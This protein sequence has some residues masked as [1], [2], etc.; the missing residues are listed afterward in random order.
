MAS[1]TTR[2]KWAGSF[3][4][5][6]SILLVAPRTSISITK[7]ARQSATGFSRISASVSADRRFGHSLISGG[8]TRGSLDNHAS[9]KMKDDGAPIALPLFFE[10]NQGQS[11]SAVRFLARSSGYTMFVTP[12]ETVFAEVQHFKEPGMQAG[13]TESDATIHAQLRMSLLNGN[14]APNVTGEHPLAG[15]VNYLIGN[16]PSQWHTKVPLYSA[17]RSKNV[18]PGI[19]L[20]F[21]GDQQRLEYDFVVSPDADPGRIRF[22]VTGAEK[23][24]LAQNGDLVLR[25]AQTEFRMRK[26]VVYQLDGG[27]RLPVRG[28][29]SLMRNGQV[30]FQL[31]AYNRKLP[32]VIDP[33]I[34]FAT[35]IGSA[36]EELPGGIDLDTTNP[37]APKLY[38]AG[39]TTDVATFA[40]TSTLLGASPGA[41]TYAF[42]A[43][44]NPAATGA[45]SLVYLTFLGGKTVF[46]GGASPCQNIAS[47]I[48][49]DTSGGVGQAEPVITG[50]T[51]CQ[52]FPVT[53]GSPTTTT[54]DFFLTRLMPTGAAL[55]VSEFL[56]GSGAQQIQFASGAELVVNSAGTI[57]LSG[58]T[59]STDLPTTPNA[60]SPAFNNGV[61]GGYDDCFVAEFDRS[62]NVKYLTY[63]N[64]GGSSTSSKSAGCGVVGVDSAGKIY[65]GGTTFSATAFNLANGGT[66]ANGFQPSFLGTPGTTPNAFAMVLDPSQTGLNQLIYST[67]ISGGG[68]A[69]PHAGA[70]DIAAG[71][72]AICGD[73][74]SNNS[75]FAPDIPLL[76]A[77]Q[78]TNAA[79]SGT[80]T[81]F[82]TIIDTTKTGSASLLASTYFG[83][84]T[85]S[86]TTVL[87]TVAFDP[88][89][90][91]P[92]ERLIIAGQTTATDLPIVNPL[93]GSLTGT[94]NSFVSVFA[95]PSSG[96]GFNMAPL[97]STYL[98]GGVA[99]GNESDSVLDLVADSN[100][101]VYAV[102]ETSSANFFGNTSPAT[103][104]SGFQSACASCS[105]GTPASDLAI[106]VLN[107]QSGAN[108][109][110]L[111]VVS[112]HIGNFA[113]G[114]NG[115]QYSIT[116]TNSGT[117]PTIGTVR[118]V[119]GLPIGLT[120]TGITGTGWNCTLAVLTCTRSDALAAGSSYPVITLTVNVAGNETS[121]V[122]NVVV[123]AGG[124]ETNIAN[125]NAI[126][127][128]IVTSQLVTPSFTGLTA[129]QS[130]PAGTSSVTL[131]GIIGSGTQFPANG[132]TVSITINGSTQ[133]AAIGA[134]GVFTLSF[135]TATLPTAGTP[136]PITY[137]YS[138]DSI[139]N[140][141]SDSSTTLTVTPAG[142]PTLLSIAVSPTNPSIAVSGIQQFIAKGTYS[143]NSTQN[144]TASVTWAS[145]AT[146]VATI[147]NAA[148]TAG[149]ATGISA[150]TATIT[151]DLGAVS[152]S[153]QLTVTSTAA[154]AYI[155]TV[156]SANCCLAALDVATNTYFR[157]I[158]T[159]TLS[160]PL[161]ITPDQR[162]IY[163]AD[164]SNNLLDVVDT[165][166]NTLVSALSVGAG[167]NAV[168]ITPDGQFGYVADYG[169]NNV[170]VF[171]VA[172]NAVV[173]SIPVGFTT[174]WISVT[175]DGS[176]VYAGSANDGRVAVINASTKALSTT[177][178]LAPFA[179]QAATGCI[180]GPTFN[181]SGTLGYFLLTCQTSGNGSVA[182]LSIP[183]N[184][185]VANIPVGITPLQA[186]ITPDGTKLYVV[187]FRTNN[188][189]VITTASNSVTSTV[190]V[191]T[192]PQSIAITPDGKVAYVANTKTGA[193]SV[194][195]TA[196]DT[197]TSNI[198]TTTPFGIIIASPPAASAAT[199][200]TFTPPNLIF[201]AQI[202]GTVSS[203]QAIQVTN[204][205]ATAI[206]FN[207]VALSGPNSADF[208][209]LNGCPVSPATLGSGSSCKLQ[210][211]YGP[212]ATGTHT[213]LVTITSTNGLAASMESIPLS[214]TGIS[215]LSIAVTPATPSIGK[216]T[217]QQFTATGTY[218]DTS[219]A[220][221]T[222][223]VKW[224]SA[225][226]AVATIN[227]SGLATGVAT[228]TSNITASL[229]A[230]SSPSDL[231]TVTAPTLQ[232]IAVTPSSPS[233]VTGGTLQLTATGTYSDTS[234]AN[235]TSQVT[236]SSATSSVATINA[237]GLATGV[238]IGTSNISASMG[239]ITSPADQLTVTTVA[240]FPLSVTPKGTGAGSVTDTSGAINCVNTAG[241]ISGTCTA[242][243]PVGAVVNLTAAPTSPSSFAGWQGA[244]TGSAG[245]SVTMNAPEAVSASFV[246]APQLIPLSFPAGANVSA[247]ATYDCPSNPN[248]TPL[249]PCLD[250]NAHAAAFTVAQVLVPF[251]LTVVATEVSPTNADGICQN[252]TSVLNDFDCRFVTFFASQTNPNGDVIVPHCYPYA[253]GDCVY[254]SVYYQMPGMEPDPS[255]YVGPV[256]WSVTFNNDAFLAP[257]PWTGGTPQLY[258][259][260]G[261]FPQANV[262]YGTDCTTP[263]LIGNPGVATN[264]P[265]FCQFDLDITTSF[266]ATK[267]VD[268]AIGGR[269]KVFSDAVVAIP[270]AN[271]PLVKVTTIPDATTVTAGDPIGF[272]ITVNNSAAGTATN[273]SLLDALPVGSN[274]S[275]SLSPAYAGQ[276]SCAITGASGNQVLNC[277]FGS[278][279]PSTTLSIHVQSPTSGAGSVISSST[280]TAANQ[281]ILSIG[282]ITV[283]PVT[284]SFGG[285]TP[286]Q[287]IPYGTPAVTLGGI[288]GS[289]GSYPPTG[290][291]V[292]VTINGVAQLAIIGSNGAFS[293]KFPTASIPGSTAPY[294]ITY[295]YLGDSIFASATDR[296]TSLAV[297]PLTQ[298]VTFG[299]LPPVAAYGST[300]R[301]TATASS[302]LP[303]TITSFG[304]CTISGGTVTMT[305]GSGECM[306]T[307]KQAGNADYQPA[308][309]T[310]SVAAAKA[311]SNSTITST[312][313]NPSLINQTVVIA[314]AVTG[315]GQPTGLV[316]VTASTGESCSGTLAAG[317]GSCSITFTT[318]G[319][320]TLL[321]SYSGDGNFNAGTSATLNQTVGTSSSS[322]VIA[323]PQLNFGEVQVG[324]EKTKKVTLL[325]AGRTPISISKILAT[326]DIGKRSDQNFSA[327]N[328]CPISLA[329]G[330]SC[331]ILVSFKPDGK[332]PRSVSAF[333]IITDSAAKSPQ[334]VP[335]TALVKIKH[336]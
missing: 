47:A 125:D 82:V 4:L 307:A 145:S 111:T 326:L 318:P 309:T 9:R 120:A 281:Q 38:V 213:A 98:G 92:T 90:G 236:W 239:S 163:L 45:A 199:A 198:P 66:G 268:Y 128:T 306:L 203:Q 33:S 131:G 142:L 202:A 150:G 159:T 144:L 327:Q 167:P 192:G 300:F 34:T 105:G 295:S 251:T 194:I 78:T 294:A 124:S 179:G 132:E 138:G 95:L 257:A 308:Q 139:F 112:S 57:V 94:P 303:V 97:F 25:A 225:I 60:Y 310:G 36:G 114:Q 182:V 330:K 315:A 168:G 219:T 201:G 185:V 149:E 109:P 16:N 240:T 289:A 172:T 180:G 205:G 89:L 151:A 331:L 277:T 293:L 189:S 264:P 273:A 286:S 265:I 107:P 193:I 173:A 271:E 258:D 304:A 166:T 206:T 272:T 44:I 53:S 122:D 115:A 56:G 157:N 226:S 195:S 174:G 275:W 311:A 266:D 147:S 146:N 158:P 241:V 256:N 267:K 79:P 35:F 262:P 76:N 102:G 229:G 259:N 19:D 234:T 233:I 230:I 103:T 46:T 119:D 12:M 232:S 17:V 123:V 65:G 280:V 24:D 27:R 244:C 164:Y 21:H 222:N 188:V 15:S 248:P 75:T 88:V 197:V 118:A 68:G 290:E 224:S 63:L 162:R 153:S 99:N 141:A 291:T 255:W 260:P 3:A 209:L 210:I 242:S 69:D 39:T 2:K 8:K 223:Q 296:T 41:S 200:L 319:N 186:A 246:P 228:G 7:P 208:V 154:T 93:Q 336:P 133:V 85:G 148:N 196:T 171:N 305:G 279:A 62:L 191:G 100:H 321:A 22:N 235:I 215:L 297:T 282:N 320:R 243:Y 288:I 237:A 190:L 325:N 108:I 334:Q 134:N 155:G 20:L 333:L 184:T 116:V 211:S 10:A 117:G 49:L 287:S 178:T 137:S 64:V 329:A 40:E 328:L 324:V 72:I 6:I 216:G 253:N 298:I 96:T 335:L 32:L 13:S 301:A 312:A 52:D 214:G 165:T 269:T 299:S 127:T 121:P 14:S 5:L 136:Y 169:D 86:G 247:M 91:S 126:D 249:N 26:P 48:K 71:L 284:V 302:G 54:V 220:D 59:T 43:E 28:G 221:I 263:M 51:S 110:D 1:A 177:L 50:G 218:S 238:G 143:D 160:Q 187:N 152:G 55:D 29:F 23:L 130:I 231:L 252:G 207:S 176:Y 316:T 37:S 67:Y 83:S 106:F 101:S 250:P 332:D 156:Q 204:P 129:S 274:L 87:R 283:Q 276:G 317:T 73:T 61:A 113:Q 285:L 278:L 161:A 183:N 11:D 170:P 81:G 18:Y 270:P 31:A 212:V 254:Y 58:S 323:P 104:V 74:T 227:A 42:V 80:A 314:F 217:T 261:G 84:P 135:L 322:L 175:P 313:P 181:P 30:S 140:S 70:A 292:S 245:C 77:Y